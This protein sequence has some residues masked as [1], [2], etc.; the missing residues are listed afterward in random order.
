MKKFAKIMAVALVAVLA[1]T[2]LVACGYPSD[3]EKAK[4]QLEKKGYT[5]ILTPAVGSIPASIT[6]TKL[7][8]EGKGE[9][10]GIMYYKDADAAKEAYNKAKES[11]EEAKKENPDV[12]LSLKRYGTQVVTKMSGDLS[13]ML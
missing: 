6:A 13:D 10:I 9:M 11:M 7:D 4:E 1:I 3:P 2:V 8:D 5:V 12:K